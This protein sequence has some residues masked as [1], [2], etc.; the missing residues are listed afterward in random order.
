MEGH[1]MKSILLHIRDD[2]GDE[3]RLQ[4]ACDIARATGAHIRCVQLSAVPELMM[5]DVYG[6]AALAPSVVE[7]LREMDDALR[8]RM[9]AR[10]ARE[11]VQ[12]DWKQWESDTV[13]GL[14]FAARLADLIVATLAQGPRQG[15]RDPLN[16][17]ADLALG[18]R[19]P[20]LAMPE[21]AD[22]FAV[23]GRAMVAWDGSAEAATALIHAV[24]LLK[25]AQAVHVVTVE[26]EDKPDFPATEAPEYL[27][28]HGIGVELHSLPRRGEPVEAVLT[29]MMETL[30]ADWMV[31]GV[32]GHSRVREMVFGGVTRRMLRDTRIPLLLAH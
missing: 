15:V 9:E 4:A 1:A 18:G 14:L 10:L 5:V 24:P 17:V 32:F 3:G 21:T 7:E 30:R 16:M 25:L 6:G 20:V 2:R 29:R 27:A 23:T 8:T 31:M 22:R 26:E 11:D 19:T 12:W 28:R 13:H